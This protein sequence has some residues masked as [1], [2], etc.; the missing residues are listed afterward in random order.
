M[1]GYAILCKKHVM[2]LILAESAE[3]GHDYEIHKN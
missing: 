1:R 2:K 3:F